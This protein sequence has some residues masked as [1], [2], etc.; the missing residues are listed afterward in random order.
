MVPYQELLF[1]P[2]LQSARR[3][4]AAGEHGGD[5]VGKDAID[6][7]AGREVDRDREVPAA[8]VPPG[9]LVQG[10]PTRHPGHR[11]GRR[12]SRPGTPR[13]RA[14]GRR[15]C[16][17]WLHRRRGG[18]RGRPW[19]STSRCPPCA[20]GCSGPSRG[21]GTGRSPCRRSCVQPCP[22]GRT[23]RS[24]RR[25]AFRRPPPRRRGRR[26]RAGPRTRRRPGRPAGPLPAAAPPGGRRA[27]D[28]GC[29]TPAIYDSQAPNIVLTAIVDAP[30]PVELTTTS[31]TLDPRTFSGV[32]V[33]GLSFLA[34]L[35]LPMCGRRHFSRLAGPGSGAAR[36]CPWRS[37]RS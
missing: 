26:P 28:A 27:P 25:T 11:A 31:D 33:A 13:R 12:P 24:R 7:R 15:R 37:S 8:G 4:V 10:D 35:V 6:Q 36:A 3:E 9:G 19:P 1:D 23:A 34:A 18:L 5:L 30:V 22:P 21:R 32:R 16:R 29:P 14:V 20:A 2:Q 17:R